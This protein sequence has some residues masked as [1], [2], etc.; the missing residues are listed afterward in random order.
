MRYAKYD[1][2]H[3]P[4]LESNVWVTRSKTHFRSIFISDLHFYFHFKE[5]SH[6]FETLENHV[7]RRV[8]GK[9]VMRQLIF[10]HVK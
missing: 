6:D 4:I 3:E 7:D 5:R 1:A 10:L 2:D 8:I 9:K